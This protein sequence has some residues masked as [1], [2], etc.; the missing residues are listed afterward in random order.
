M[1]HPFY[2]RLP[3]IAKLDSQI[4]PGQ[5]L[6]VRGQATGDRVV[7]NL[8]T[9]QDVEGGTII[10]HVSCRSKDK[11][12]V[13]NTFENGAW[14]KEERFKCS[15]E[16]S[17]PFVAR[18]RCHG[19]KYEVFFDGKEIGEFKYRLPLASVTYVQVYGELT[20]NSVGWE[21]NYYSVPYKIKIPNNFTR[22]RKLFLTFVPDSEKF[23]VDLLAGDDIAFHFNPRFNQ[24]KT[25][26]NSCFGGQWGQ[27]EIVSNLPFTK[28]KG[29]DV[30]IVCENEQYA[31]YVN[32]DPYCTFKH[33]IDPNKI[34]GLAIGPGVELQ[35]V[36]FE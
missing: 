9:S 35:V 1:A 20:L 26:N 21:G 34:D 27:E 12:F 8:A 19:D 15:I 6:V 14:G 30:L 33:R 16:K 24:K 17:Q 3:Y 5:S 10:L 31:I 2:L 36:N 13:L 23:N 22:Q 25:V 18:I 11:V 4:E 32:A 7:I 28:K 29:V